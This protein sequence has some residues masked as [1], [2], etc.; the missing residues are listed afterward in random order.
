MKNFGVVH[1]QKSKYL[2]KLLN[3]MK[4]DQ[5]FFISRRVRRRLRCEC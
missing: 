5:K 4:S 1:N 2:R 3:E